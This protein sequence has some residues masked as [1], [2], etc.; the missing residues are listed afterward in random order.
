[1]GNE[2]Q[3]NL[4]TIEVLRDK[5]KTPARVFEGLKIH[6]DWK[7]GKMVT[8]EDYLKAQTQFLGARADGK[9]ERQ[10]KKDVK[11]R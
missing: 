5:C 2:T 7:A 9:V 11:G 6:Q 3:K 4:S 1:M 10:V 8:E